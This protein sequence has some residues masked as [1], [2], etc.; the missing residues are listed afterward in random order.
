MKQ[1]LEETT[2]ILPP[3]YKQSFYDSSFFY[4]LKTPIPKLN[5]R[6]IS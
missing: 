1:A 5:S 4:V 3:F 2:L 6:F